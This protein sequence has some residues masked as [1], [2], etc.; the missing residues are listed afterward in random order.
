MHVITALA[1]TY[2]KLIVVKIESRNKILYIPKGIAHGFL[3]LKDNTI[4]NYKC[5]NLYNPN[6]ESG[7]NIFKSKINFNFGINEDDLI[8]SD[9]DR[10]LPS[11]EKSYIFKKWKELYLRV[12]KEVD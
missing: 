8:I 1:K 2:K 4:V 11:L 9:K 3:S 6:Y 10:K 12:V 7:V 5:D